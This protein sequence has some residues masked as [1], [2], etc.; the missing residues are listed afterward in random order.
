MFGFPVVIIRAFVNEFGFIAQN[1]KAVCEAF[2]YPKLAFVFS[3]Q[4]FARPFAESRRTFA[5]ID[6]NVKY[7]ADNNA[8]E[9]ALRVFGLV[10]QAAQYAF[11]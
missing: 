11:A 5:H 8:D 9:F 1:V 3:R 7:F 10:M 4:D 2:R 6:G